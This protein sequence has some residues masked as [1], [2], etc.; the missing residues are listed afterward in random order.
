MANVLGRRVIPKGGYCPD[1]VPGADRSPPDC[2]LSRG[3]A[4]P[5]PPNE[6]RAESGSIISIIVGAETQSLLPPS[7]C[8]AGHAPS[9]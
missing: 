9:P 2:A 8:R 6:R 7:W 1:A 4:P 3:P 5:C